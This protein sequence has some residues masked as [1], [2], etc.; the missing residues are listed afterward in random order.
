MVADRQH[1][2]MRRGSYLDDRG[3]KGFNT[4]LV[5]LIEHLFSSGSAA[6]L[7]GD[8]PFTTP[9]TSA[10]RTRPISP[11][12]SGSWTAPS[13]AS[14]RILAPAYL[15]YP[16]SRITRALRHPE[17]W[18]DESSPPAPMAAGVRASTWADAS[19]AS[20]TSSGAS[21][22]TGTRTRRRRR[23]SRSPRGLRAPAS[24]T[25]SPPTCCR[26]LAGRGFAG[27]TGST[28][29]SRTPTDRPSN[30]SIE[31]WR[32]DPAWPFFLIES[33][34]EGEH[35]ASDLQI[36]RQAYWSVLCGGNGHIMGNKPIWLFG[37]GW[38]SSCA[39]RARSRWPAGAHSS[40]RCRGRAGPRPRPRDRGRRAGRGAR[41]RSRDRGGDA[42][43]AAGR[44]LPALSPSGDDRYGGTWRAAGDCQLVRAG[45]GRSCRR[46]D[47]RRRR[48][49]E[50]A[51]P[52]SDD[53][54]LTM[55]A[56]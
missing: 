42:R 36:R 48:T 38:Q 32:R 28:S 55:R 7:A 15:G 22:A 26:R 43:S 37:T 50:L 23:S 40:A 29:T 18:Y 14:G 41:P 4:L 49:V 45:H 31:D 5:S 13:A 6:N 16:R 52:F 21:V 1:D 9:A 11:T 33:T 47:A 51:P 53:A 19:A 44:R 24:T 25:C 8:E 17:G 54:V 30:S 12:P 27:S 3:P 10:R 56:K 2:S 39:A 46:G 20:R 35:N 34:Y